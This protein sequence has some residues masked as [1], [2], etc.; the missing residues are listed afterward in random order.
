MILNKPQTTALDFLQ[1]QVTNEVC[2]GG[3]AGPGKSTL[4]CYWQLKN[5]I[6]YP[7]TNGLIGRTSLKTLKE[8]TLL[9]FHNVAKMQGFQSSYKLYKE[10][11]LRFRNGSTIFLKDLFYYPADPDVDEM[12]SLELTDAGVDEAS[13]VNAKVR[14]VLNSRIRYKL[15][16]NNLIPKAL[17]VTNPGK[18]WTKNDF[19]TP[20]MNG[21]LQIDRQ[22]V[23]A[24]LRDNKNISR[25]YEANL[26]K[27]SK[28][29]RDR[30]LLGN[31][32]YA[33]DPS[34][35]MTSES[36]REIFENTH[37]KTEGFH[38]YITADIARKGNDRIIIRL[39]HGWKV[40]A[41]Y[42]YTK[43]KITETAEKIKLIAAA[44]QIPMSRVIADEDGIGGGV[45]DILGCKGF[46]ANARPNDNYKNKNNKNFAS[47][48]DQ[49]AWYLA[50]K[51]TSALVYE[52]C[53]DS[54]LRDSIMEEL[55]W[56]K[57]AGLNKDGKNKA[58][59]KD[60]I[61]EG[62]GRSP[63]DSD[64]YLMRSWFDINGSSGITLL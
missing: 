43:L 44:N 34:Q 28:Q 21:V 53:G 7:G 4:L 2:F 47:N 9:T 57:D 13:Q 17:Y 36:I 60:K 25:H 55:E 35:L 22:F 45:V 18:N 46:I 39:W 51:V 58:V 29:L 59:S 24:F 54:V 38:K 31:W 62:I 14:E 61:C 63:D 41:R 40:L 52:S 32:N 23:P 11:E 49:C 6:K 30:L 16:E 64:T 48:K 3:S 50:D 56:I 8:T 33:D 10:S 42:E 37:V 12:G 27:L 26:R 19:Y 1:D 15:D 20:W 5:R